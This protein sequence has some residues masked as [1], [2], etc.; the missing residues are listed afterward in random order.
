MFHVARFRRAEAVRRIKAVFGDEITNK[1]ALRVAR[2][3]LRN[4]ILN[5]IEMM[6]AERIDKQWIDRNI[7][8]FGAR[9]A[10]IKPIIE[11]HGGAIIAVPH[12]GNW[13]LAGWACQRYG[14]PMISIGG[15]QKNPLVNRW[16]N[17]QRERGMI[18]LDRG[19]SST[20]KQ[21]LRMLRKGHVLAILP[22]V[23]MYDADLEIDFLG[24]K[25]NLGRG[26]AQFAITAGVPIIPA[27]FKRVGLTGHTGERFD[28]V[29]PDPALSKAEN[30]QKMTQS[31]IN[32]IDRFI[33]QEP[34][35]WFWYNKRW[36]LTPIKSAT[37]RT[38]TVV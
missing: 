6:R 25:A 7:P 18:M 10:E 13:D 8:D 28:I 15:K 26:M 33:R 32:I 31:V 36:V 35:Q 3:S 30:I 29:V 21:M 37:E 24:A 34:E 22:D 1:D 23:R 27:V 11:E 5:I 17:K 19:D 4:L 12:A 14:I 9:I 16:I 38:T 20:L 2:I